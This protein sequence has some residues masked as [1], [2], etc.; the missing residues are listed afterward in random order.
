MTMFIFLATM[1]STSVFH[2]LSLNFTLSLQIRLWASGPL[3]SGGR[4]SPHMFN[5]QCSSTERISSGLFANAGAA[6]NAVAPAKKPFRVISIILLPYANH[7][8]RTMRREPGPV[9]VR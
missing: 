9:N 1:S 6:A 4:D 5:P 8:Y 2:A 3:M 7:D